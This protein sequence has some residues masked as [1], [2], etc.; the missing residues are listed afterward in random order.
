[1][2]TVVSSSGQESLKVRLRRAD[3]TLRAVRSVVQANPGRFHPAGLD[4][5]AP[6]LWSM[7]AAL[8]DLLIPL[9]WLTGAA[10][11]FPDDPPATAEAGPQNEQ[12][13][14]DTMM[15]RLTAVLAAAVLST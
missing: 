2:L 5:G 7:L 10:D 14:L 3:L 15:P 12:L 9:T 4:S 11:K 13:L 8:M 6:R 1:L